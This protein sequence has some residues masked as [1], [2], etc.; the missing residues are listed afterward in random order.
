MKKIFTL[1]VGVTIVASSFAQYR[2]NG[3]KDDGYKKGNDAVYN[4]RGYKKDDNR[5]N[6]YYSFSVKERDMQIAKIN[7]EYDWKV[8]DVRKKFYMPRFKKEQMIR[9]LDDQRRNEIRMLYARFSDRNNRYNDHDWR[10]H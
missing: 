3:G 5:Y 9:Q 6:N 7:R 8:Q 1:L 10:D 4:D 2:S